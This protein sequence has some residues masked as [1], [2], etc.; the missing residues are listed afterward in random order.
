MSNINN[1][2]LLER[3][4]VCMEYFE[5]KLPAQVIERDIEQ[6]DLEALRY[7][8]A[9]AEGIISQEIIAGADLV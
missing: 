7:H 6:G 4:G 5:S 9:E 3:A 8:V 1:D 2:E